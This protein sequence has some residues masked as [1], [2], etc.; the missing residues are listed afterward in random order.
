MTGP[1]TDDVYQI[2]VDTVGSDRVELVADDCGYLT[3]VAVLPEGGS[4][5]DGS[6]MMVI[7]P[8]SEGGYTWTSYSAQDYDHQPMMER[9]L[10]TDG[11]N[12]VAT[13]GDAIRKQA[14]K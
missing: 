1:T 8:E 13:L 2:A 10:T 5:A 14:A 7:G 11:D 3:I 9:Y 12:T 6:A 4:V